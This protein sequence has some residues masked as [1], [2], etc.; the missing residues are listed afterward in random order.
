[1]FEG[2]CTK[3][4]Y[5]PPRAAWIGRWISPRRLTHVFAP[6]AC[7]AIDRPEGSFSPRSRTTVHPKSTVD[8]APTCTLVSLY[9]L[10]QATMHMQDFRLQSGT[11]RGSRGRSARSA[12][13]IVVRGSPGRTGGLALTVSR[14]FSTWKFFSTRVT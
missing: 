1:M 3:L 13:R 12:T 6:I 9:K 10:P 7:S 2:L 8:V 11:D 4:R 14:Y 5:N